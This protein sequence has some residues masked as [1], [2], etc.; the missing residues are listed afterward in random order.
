MTKKY[1][2]LFLVA[3]L[4]GLAYKIFFGEKNIKTKPNFEAFAEFNDQKGIYVAFPNVEHVAGFSNQKV[5]AEIIKNVL[6]YATIHFLVPSDSALQVFRP[7]LS[8]EDRKNPNLKIVKMPYQEF[9]LRDMG[10]VF[11]SNGQTRAMLDYNFNGWGYMDTLDC[12]KDEKVDELIAKNL[13]IPIISNHLVHE[14]GDT[15]LN[16]KGTLIVVEAVEQQRNP[17]LSINQMTTIF[18]QTMGV[19]KVIWLKKGV[20]EDDF[21]FDGPIALEGGKMGYTL[22]TTGGHI[23]EFCRFV[24]PNTLLLA[25]VDAADLNDPIAVENKIRLEENYQILKN[26]TD[27]DGKP[28]NIIRMPMPR[29]ITRS[30]TPNDWVYQQISMMN[31]TKTNIPFPKGKPVTGIMA[32]SYLNFLITKGVVLAQKYYQTGMDETFK[33]R[34][35]Q[36]KNILQSIFPDK[37]IIQIDATPVNWGGGGIHCITANDF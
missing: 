23:D 26:A 27:Q 30:L 3:L 6:P 8:E 16:G 2:I 5:V 13:S 32:S 21:T 31:Y 28:F 15:E 7:N 24:T 29:T 19:K 36:S 17:H 37:K 35:E 33:T 10:P 1:I 4:S 20:H 14:G 22:L 18:Q 34:D 25:Q 11:L 12:Q 9:W